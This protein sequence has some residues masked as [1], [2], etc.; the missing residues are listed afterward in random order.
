MNNHRPDVVFHAAAYK[1]VPMLESQLLTAVKNNIFATRVIADLSVQYRVKAFVL[2]SSDKAVN[3]TNIM[4]LSKRIAE[5]YCQNLNDRGQ[6]HFVTVRFGNVLGSTGSV[7]P[8]FR[9]Q[10][11]AGGPITVTHPQ[12]TRYFM[13]IPE[14]TSLILQS[15]SMGSGGEIYVLD[16]GN[17]VKITYLAEQMIRLA[18]KVPNKDIKIIYTGIRP[19]EK[20][21]EE[22]F[23]GSEEL[24]ATA[25]H[26]I[27]L[28]DSR[29]LDWVTLIKAFDT[30]EL[31]YQSDDQ[32]TI[33]TVLKDLV[34]EYKQTVVEM[35]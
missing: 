16:M 28:A 12:M 7:V 21:F 32:E 1:H 31:A 13:T 5:I 30:I 8:L 22:L 2:V 11:E 18:G 23:H 15:Y 35:E 27:S 4:G 26:K 10:L 19:G 34:P 24:K 20:M 9:K 17:P 14:A 29:K 3:P 6:T 33:L 25:H